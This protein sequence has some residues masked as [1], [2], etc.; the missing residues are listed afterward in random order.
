MTVRTTAAILA[1]TILCS[2][3][4]TVPAETPEATYDHFTGWFEVPIPISERR[5]IHVPEQTIIVPVIKRGTNFFTPQT[6]RVHIPTFHI[7][8]ALPWG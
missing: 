3:F 7:V 2:T 5:H 1:V 4:S 6:T 8:L